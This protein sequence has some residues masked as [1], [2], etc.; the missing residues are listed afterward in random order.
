ME[1]PILVFTRKYCKDNNIRYRIKGNNKEL[2]LYNPYTNRFMQV[3]Y[4]LLNLNEEQVAESIGIFLK[5][6]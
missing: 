6:I 5:S 1:Q 2:W 4:S 3:C